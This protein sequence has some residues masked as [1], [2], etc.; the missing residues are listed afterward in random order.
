M[1]HIREQLWDHEMFQNLQD[2]IQESVTNQI[3][4]MTIIEDEL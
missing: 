4:D 3:D 2:E 1:A